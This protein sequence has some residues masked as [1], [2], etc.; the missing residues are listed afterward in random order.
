MFCVELWKS[1]GELLRFGNLYV[2]YVHSD[3]Y[4]A[5]RGIE[6]IEGLRGAACQCD[7]GQGSAGF[8]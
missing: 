3:C 1:P 4:G 2:N 6:K 8:A 5:R 7:P